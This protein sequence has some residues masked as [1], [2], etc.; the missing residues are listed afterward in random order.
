MKQ[1]VL[2][3]DVK[4]LEEDDDQNETDVV[5]LFCIILYTSFIFS[6]H[7]LFEGEDYNN[8]GKFVLIVSNL[9]CVFPIVQAQGIWMKVLLFCTALSS[10]MWHWFEIGLTLPGDPVMYGIVDRCLSVMSIASYCMQWLPIPYHKTKRK[11]CLRH[12]LGPPQETAEWRCRFTVKLIVNMMI[13][14]GVGLLVYQNENIATPLGVGLIVFIVLL[15]LGY[16]ASGTMT[17]PKK[18]KIKFIVCVLCGTV[19][20]LAAFRFNKA[21]ES[22]LYN[23]SLW[24]AYIHSSAYC[25]SRA[26]EYL[27]LKD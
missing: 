8:V 1:K 22:H 25:F 10:I 6:R 14:C 11:D 16:I 4:T 23:H 21:E 20:G 2:P 18:F 24:H 15:S 19:F 5:F 17:I 13:T 7:H 27:E 12:W 26:L 3:T 9:F